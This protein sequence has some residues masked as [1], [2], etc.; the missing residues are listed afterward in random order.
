MADAAIG[1]A[2][3]PPDTASHRETEP[4]NQEK[5]VQTACIEDRLGFVRKVYGILSAQLI[6]TVVIA[7]PL[8]SMTKPWLQSHAA[9]LW[10]SL[11]MT[12]VTMCAISCCRNAA[13]KFPTNYIFLF[14]FTIFEGVVVGFVSAEYTW[15]SVIL[16]TAITVFIF[17]MMTAYACMSTTDFTGAGPYLFAGMMCMLAF[18]FVLAIMNA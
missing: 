5:W 16:A 13:R 1:A 2:I 4:F 9:V 12:M 18:G 10:V 6:L 14:T 17:L 7:F 11:V 8:Q 15:Q 3:M